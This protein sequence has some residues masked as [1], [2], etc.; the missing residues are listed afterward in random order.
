L[1]KKFI[2]EN[3]PYIDDS[4]EIPDEFFNFWSKERE[5]AIQHLSKEEN[6]D[7]EKLQQVI[8]DYLFTERKPLRNDSIHATNKR[9]TLKERGNTAERITSKILLFIYT[10]INGISGK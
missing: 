4:D 1:I 7:T 6:L 2:Q 10:F 5:D 3:L 8:G 9:P